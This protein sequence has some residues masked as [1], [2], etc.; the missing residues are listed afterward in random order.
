MTVPVADALLAV[1]A[2]HRAM[3]AR[4]YAGAARL[5]TKQ[6]TLDGLTGLAAPVWQSEA[7]RA[8]RASVAAWRADHEATL[9]RRQERDIRAL[10]ALVAGAVTGGAG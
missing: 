8:Y 6:A 4:D 2:L 10:V 9:R 3:A 7:E 5:V 1:A